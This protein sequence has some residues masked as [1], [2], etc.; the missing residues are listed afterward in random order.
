M[1]KDMSVTF[2]FEFTQYTTNMENIFKRLQEKIDSNKKVGQKL[3]MFARVMGGWS[4]QVLVLFFANGVKLKLWSF[5][6]FFL[7]RAFVWVGLFCCCLVS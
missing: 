4:F 5:I 3:A 6:L 1:A 2:S 7:E